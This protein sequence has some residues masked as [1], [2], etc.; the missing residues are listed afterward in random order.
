M[1]RRWLAALAA[2]ALAAPPLAADPPPLSGQSDPAFQAARDLW[3]DGKEAEALPALA[4]LAA[5]GNAAAQVLLGLIDTTPQ[6][7]GPW[8][9]AQPRAERIALLRAP[10]G[11]SG[12]NW[13]REAALTEPLAQAWLRLWD[14]DADVQVMLDFAAMDE[15]HAA[16]VAAKRLARRDRK[17]FG[18]VA[19]DP[20][21]PAFARA[22]AIRDWQTGDPARAEAAL[23]ALPG[24]DPGRALLGRHD[25]APDALLDLAASDPALGLL[26]LHLRV[27]CPGPDGRAERLATALKMIGGWWGLAD[28]G[29]PAET[30]VDRQTWVASAQGI[31]AFINVLPDIAPTA[32]PPGDD[33]CLGHLAGLSTIRRQ[34]GE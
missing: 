9:S 34:G 12:R 26:D 25:P 10:G 2:L 18:A 21:F 23:A 27:V 14:G 22:L 15:V 3:L 8:L 1:T 24:A 19:D 4:G 32:D 11:L 16:H 29:P 30:L 31:T 20:D 7:Q 33:L 28:L 17:G 5:G 13:M 6:Y